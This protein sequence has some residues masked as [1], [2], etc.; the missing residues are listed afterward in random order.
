LADRALKKPETALVLWQ[1][2]KSPTTK[3][4]EDEPDMVCDLCNNKLDWEPFAVLDWPSDEEL[5]DP[6]YVPVGGNALCQSCAKE[7]YSLTPSDVHKVDRIRYYR[8][9]VVSQRRMTE[10]PVS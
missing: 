10:H 7:K 4:I 6:E 2:R 8:D 5:N 3:L 9:G 1:V